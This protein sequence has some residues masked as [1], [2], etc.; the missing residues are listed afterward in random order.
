MYAY[1][2]FRLGL[3]FP[4]QTW[5]TKIRFYP[6]MHHSMMS[7]EDLKRRFNFKY[8]NLCIWKEHFQFENANIL[9]A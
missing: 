6:T 4:K 5:K 8:L 3:S 9:I 7:Y 1:S 2:N